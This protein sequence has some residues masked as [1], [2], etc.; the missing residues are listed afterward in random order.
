MRRKFNERIRWHERKWR[1]KYGDMAD[2]N[3]AYMQGAL[4][5]RVRVPASQLKSRMMYNRLRDY[6]LES[7]TPQ[8]K[9]KREAMYRESFEKLLDGAFLFTPS[10]RKRVHAALEKMTADQIIDYQIQFHPDGIGT[11]Y[12]KY[13]DHETS[14]GDYDVEAMKEASAEVRQLERY[15][16]KAGAKKPKAKAKKARK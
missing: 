13:K 7:Q 14:I 11:I 10:E 8:F 16:K 5:I 12:D 3:R 9:A 2:V 6:M 15:A 1:Y 4:P